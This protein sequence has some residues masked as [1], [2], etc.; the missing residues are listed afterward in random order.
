MPCLAL[1]FLSA[2]FCS[3]ECST[4]FAKL[5]MLY[6]LSFCEIPFVHTVATWADIYTFIYY[7]SESTIN[8]LCKFQL[9][10]CL[11]SYHY[12]DTYLKNNNLIS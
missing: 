1:V 4:Q 12:S 9:I 5:S 8:V 3:A 6:R 2:A 11:P 7:K 10:I